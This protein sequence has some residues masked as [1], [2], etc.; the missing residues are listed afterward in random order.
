MPNSKD[1]TPSYARI[2]A[3]VLDKIRSGEYAVGTRIPSEIELAKMFSVSRIT[4]NKALKEL[5][6][7]GVLE[8]VRGRKIGFPPLP[9]PLYRPRV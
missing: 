9:R 8:R 7:M 4:A 2:Q 5:S 3:F 1:V 6:L